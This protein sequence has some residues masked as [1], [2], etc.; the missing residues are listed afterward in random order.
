MS[1]S[2]LELAQIQAEA[3]RYLPD[4]CTIQTPARTSDGMGGWTETYANTFANVPC[5]IWMQTGE[6]RDVA[7]RVSEITRWV[8]NVPYDQELTPTQR[9]V[10][11]AHIYQVNDA[12]DD[13]SQLAH[14]RATLTRI[15]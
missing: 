6:E 4:L 8:I 7:G 5:H 10:H 15:V 12:N 11:G 2:T 3:E 13:G 1:L 14:V 9:V